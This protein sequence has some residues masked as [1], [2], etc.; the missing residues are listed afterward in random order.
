[1]GTRAEYLECTLAECLRRV[2]GL[3]ETTNITNSDAWRS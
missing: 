2:L 3:Q 1:M